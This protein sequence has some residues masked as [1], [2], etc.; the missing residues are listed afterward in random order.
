M[1]YAIKKDGLSW[2]AV[3]SKKDCT[4]DEI[5]SENQPELIVEMTELIV[6]MGKENALNAVTV[7]TS[8]GKIFNGNETARNNMLSAIVASD[9]LKQ[10]KSNWRLADNTV[11]EVTLDEIKEALALSIQK[12]GEIITS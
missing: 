5:Y 7:K 11:A 10:T 3:D 12:V 4:T 8:S 6:E 9:Y 2:R 1:A